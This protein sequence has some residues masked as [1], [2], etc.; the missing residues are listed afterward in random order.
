MILKATC[1]Y[2]LTVGAT[3]LPPGANVQTDSE[4]AVIKFGSGGGL[5]NIYPIPSYQSKAVNEYLTNHK[6]HYASC[7]A[8]NDRG[9]GARG[10]VY[11]RNRREYPD[12]SAVGD[13]LVIFNRGMPVLIGGTS[14]SAPVWPSLIN[15]INEERLAAGEPTVGFVNP[16]LYANPGIMHDIATGNNPGCNTNGFSA[17]TGW[18]P[19]TGLGTP[20]YPALL[21]LFMNQ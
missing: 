13:N 19:V 18:D 9:I 1:P 14:A 5:S 20:N 11:N 8:I 7:S 10:G 16:T 2:L 21:K 6:P 15:R 12:V 4:V 3:Y 17:S